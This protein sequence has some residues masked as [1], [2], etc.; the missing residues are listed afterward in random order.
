MATAEL[1]KRGRDL[2]GSAIVID[3]LNASRLNREYL[4]KIRE[5]G[6]TGINFT[7]AMMDNLSETVKKIA[8][9][10]DLVHKSKSVILIES[11]A[12]L[13]RAKE[14]GLGGIILGFQ[15]IFPLEENLSLVQIY[16]RLGVRIIQ[17]SYHFRNACGDGCVEAERE[18]A[19]L[20]LFGEKLVEK[21]ND[22]HILI[23]LAHVGNRTGLE[24]VAKSRHPVVA[25]HSNPMA[26]KHAYQNKTDELMRAIAAKG[27]VIC[28]T[29]FPRMLP[30]DDGMTVEDFI[31][32]IDYVV[33]LVGIDHV[34]VGTDM[35]EGWTEDPE[36]YKML[37]EIDGRV[38]TWPEGL[39]TITDMRDLPGHLLARGYGEE[40]IVK[41][42]GGNLQRVFQEVWGY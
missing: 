42:I 13:K 23:D 20:S 28:P 27:G 14:Q 34:G 39:R 33:D 12:D 26:L 8:N 1:L 40:D 22:Y 11:V 7:I 18:D 32:Q 4:D 3:G 5:A 16:Q 41:I 17:L 36:R 19:G 10:N 24:A 21:L 37:I 38:Y 25:S 29:A 15:N 2:Y 6:V 30:R 9:L 31:D 35:C